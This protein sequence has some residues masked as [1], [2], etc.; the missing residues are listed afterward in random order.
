MQLKKSQLWGKIAPKPQVQITWDQAK[1]ISF[2]KLYNLGNFGDNFPRMMPPTNE[3]P[4]IN[5]HIV[6]NFVKYKQEGKGFQRNLL[7]FG[8]KLGLKF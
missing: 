8:P 4:S 2:D 7:A 5:V 3:Q 1:V 6:T